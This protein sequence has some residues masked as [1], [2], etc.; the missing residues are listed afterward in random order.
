MIT[1]DSNGSV[2]IIITEKYS[3]INS[4]V[5]EVKAILMALNHVIINNWTSVVVKS[6]CKNATKGF[7]GND[8]DYH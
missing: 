2:L 4:L 7:E 3:E 6:D 8:E 1:R 5:V